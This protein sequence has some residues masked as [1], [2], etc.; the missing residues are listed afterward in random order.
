MRMFATS[1]LISQSIGPNPP[2]AGLTL[3]FNDDF[4]S[5]NGNSTGS[6]GWLTQLA[7]GDGRTR[8]SNNEAEYYVD[9]SVNP[10]GPGGSNP[11]YTPFSTS[12]SILTIAATKASSTGANDGGLPYN[13]GSLSSINSFYMRYGYWECR[14]QVPAGVGLWPAFWLVSVDGNDNLEIDVMEQ[15]GV[16]TQIY[17]TVHYVTGGP[18]TDGGT[19]T[20]VS[21][22]TTGFHT[23]GV[24]WEPTN[25]TFYFDGTQI[26]QFATRADA[27]VAMAI[28]LNLA[29]GGSGSWPGPPNGSTAFP[30][31]LQVDWVRAW[32]SSNSTAIGG[33]K[34]LP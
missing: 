21:D 9:P 11:G 31:N 17:N 34:A 16:N 18:G 4:T 33:S 12:S 2:L 8:A 22:T 27:G 23:Y 1:G 26:N 19:A 30:A 29:V 24:D 28:Y 32:A 3:K 5:F 14:M 10:G 13:S 20:T 15:I 25:T 7:F 6:N